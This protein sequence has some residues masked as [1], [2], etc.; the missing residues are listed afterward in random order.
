[1]IFLALLRSKSSHLNWCRHAP[2]CKQSSFWIVAIL[3]K[4]IIRDYMQSVHSSLLFPSSWRGTDIC[5][6]WYIVFFIR[7]VVLSIM[8][9]TAFLLL[10]GTK[11]AMPLSSVSRIAVIN[12][13][14]FWKS[15]HATKLLTLVILSIRKTVRVSLE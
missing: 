12:N 11:I 1:M 7:V 3:S 6:W 2:V 9:L 10:R 14:I 13:H 4:H 8:I 5:W 15:Y